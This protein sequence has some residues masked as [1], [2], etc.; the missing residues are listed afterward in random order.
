MF[1][2]QRHLELQ[3][4]LTSWLKIGS[5]GCQVQE[6]AIPPRPH[7][8]INLTV[9]IGQESTRHRPKIH[10]VASLRV[11]ERLLFVSSKLRKLLHPRLISEK[12]DVQAIPVVAANHE[13]PLRYGRF[14]IRL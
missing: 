9:D 8:L 12:F 13:S 7:S 14:M 10:L 2:A 11:G 3:Q 4:W 5:I 1:Y 6:L